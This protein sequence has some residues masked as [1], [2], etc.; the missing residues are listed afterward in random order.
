[1]TLLDILNPKPHTI[2]G[3]RLVIGMREAEPIHA[4]PRPRSRTHCRK[5][6]AKTPENTYVRPDGRTDCRVC[7][8]A[9]EQSRRK[10]KRIQTH[11]RNGAHERSPENLVSGGGGRMVCKLCRREWDK[12]YRKRRAARKA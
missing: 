3:A 6:H 2:V 7:K 10:P 5:G 11:C 8:A 4:A 1:M 9:I 12:E